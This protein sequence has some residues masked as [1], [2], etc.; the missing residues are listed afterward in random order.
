MQI[1]VKRKYSKL[2]KYAQLYIHD[3]E[4]ELKNRMANFPA[5][6]SK[7]MKNLQKLMHKYNPYVKLFKQR[8]IE[9]EKAPELKLV[10]K[11]NSKKDRRKDNIPSAS[12]VAAIIPGK[13][14]F[15]NLIYNQKIYS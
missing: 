3:T 6:D 2:I 12:E 4:N 14:I 10:L 11:A 5:L 15:S 1:A 13:L 8:A 9:I 7:I